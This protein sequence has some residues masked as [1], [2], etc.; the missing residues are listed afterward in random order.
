MAKSRGL[1][2]GVSTLDTVRK[3]MSTTGHEQEKNQS[4]G[5]TNFYTKGYEVQNPENGA[6]PGSRNK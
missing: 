1:R 4:L 5:D 6:R 2:S 3:Y